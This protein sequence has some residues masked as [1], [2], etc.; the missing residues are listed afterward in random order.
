MLAKEYK[1]INVLEATKKRL[2][3]V[4]DEFDNIMVSISGG[5]DSEVLCY[6][7]L[8]EARKRGRKI[9]IFFLDEEVVYQSTIEMVEYL[10]SMYP[11]NTNRFWV[12]IPF[13]LSNST[14]YTDNQLH[15]WEQAKKPVWMHKRSSKNI[16][17]KT[18]S[19]KTRVSNKLKGF[20]FYDLLYNFELSFENTAF[21]VGLRADESLNRY[22]DRKSVV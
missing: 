8:Q 7:A 21:L 10:M 15:A 13:N 17:N 5:K 18:W 3:Y 16:L 6:L 19:H 9:G 1:D 14:S 22:R 4:F 2:E 12:Q 11:E 20:G